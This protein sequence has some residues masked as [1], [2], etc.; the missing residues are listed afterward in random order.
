MADTKK[1]IGIK[2]VQSKKN[3]DVTYY[4]YFYTSAHSNYDVENASYLVGLA[5]GSEFTSTDIG[6]NVG[7]EVEFFYSK[8]FEDKA[9]LAGCRVVK[10]AQTSVPK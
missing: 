3:K 1:I 9:V 8:G 5:C 2:A 10:P 6:C 4:T 7:D